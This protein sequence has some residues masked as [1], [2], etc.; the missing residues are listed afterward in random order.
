MDVINDIVNGNPQVVSL[1]ISATTIG[2]VQ[3]VKMFVKDKRYWSLSSII[4][5]I[6]FGILYYGDNIR[7]GILVGIVI[8]LN[9]IGLWSGIK[10][11]VGIEGGRKKYGN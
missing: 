2:L 9:A 1:V 10:N 6:L 11:T 7:T 3:I 5:G 4:I 8:G